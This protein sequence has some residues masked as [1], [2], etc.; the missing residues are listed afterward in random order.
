VKI[1]ELKTHEE[2]FRAVALGLKHHEFRKDDRGFEVGDVLKLIGI[3]PG[4]RGE[5]SPLPE[6]PLFVAVTYITRGP[7]FDVPEGYVV[8]SIGAPILEGGIR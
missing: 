5:A 4:I 6:P 7:A 8:M 2:A 3:E 1:H